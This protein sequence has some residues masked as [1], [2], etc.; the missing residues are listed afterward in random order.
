MLPLVALVDETRVR[1]LPEEVPPLIVDAPPKVRVVPVEVIIPEPGLR[2]RFDEPPDEKVPVPVEEIVNAPESVRVLA[3][4]VSVPRTVPAA[5]LP[6]PEFEILCVP[7][8]LSTPTAIFRLPPAVNN[9]VPVVTAPLLVVCRDKRLLP[10]SKVEAAPPVRLI[11]PEPSEMVN[12]PVPGPKIDRAVVPVKVRELPRFKVV[13][14]A[15]R[16]RDDALAVPIDIVPLELAPTPTSRDR[17]PEVPD[18]VVPPVWMVIPPELP[19]EPAAVLR[20][21]ALPFP[22][23][24]IVTA[25]VALGA[26]V[27]FPEEL[28]TAKP[29]TWRALKA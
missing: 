25:P 11:D 6:V 26:T 28:A 19:E 21:R 22:L 8:R 18:E 3:V 27:K 15:P 5:K 12:P 7:P 14:E 16:V 23:V 10:T 17:D 2:A 24:L 20:V 1:V 13:L 29:F 9:P 4:K